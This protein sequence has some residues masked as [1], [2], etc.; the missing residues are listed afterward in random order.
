MAKHVLYG[1]TV[2]A[3]VVALVWVVVAPGFEPLL[4]FLAGCGSLVST[5]LLPTNDKS[6][7]PSVSFTNTGDNHGQQAGINTGTMTQHNQTIHNQT[8]NQGAQGQ[9]HGPVTFNQGTV[10]AREDEL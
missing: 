8:A 7:G 6:G 3:W 4:A 2:V 10:D 9:F 1:I 5:F